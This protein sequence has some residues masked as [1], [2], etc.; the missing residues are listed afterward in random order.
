MYHKMLIY[1]GNMKS[2][3]KWFVVWWSGL[4]TGWTSSLYNLIYSL[5]VSYGYRVY[6]SKRKYDSEVAIISIVADT[7]E[8]SNHSIDST[9]SATPSVSS[10]PE[11]G[12]SENGEKSAMLSTSL[13]TLTGNLSTQTIILKRAST[14]WI[15]MK[16]CNYI[17][18]HNFL[19]QF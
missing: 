12:V 9:S 2:N 13:L 1:L 5:E 17:H 14:K 4:G 3:Y 11:V 15:I 19:G 7:S 10:P 8:H 16:K 6:I 18:D